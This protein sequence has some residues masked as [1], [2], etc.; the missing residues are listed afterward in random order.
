[1]PRISWTLGPIAHRGLHR[2]SRGIVENTISAV[3][4]AIER[5][6]AVEVDLQPAKG[7]AP[8]VFHDDEL[9]RLIDVK[10]LVKH[11]TPEEL[12]RLPY[13]ATRDRIFTLDELLEE[14]RGRVPLVVEVKTP[15]VEPGT[16]EAA[17]ARACKLYKGPLA[18]MSFDHRSLVALRALAPGIPLGLLSYRW[19]DDWMPS[20]GRWEKMKLR[21]LLYRRAVDAAFVAYDIDDLPAGPPLRARRRGLPLLTWTVTTEAQRQRAARYADAI[22]FEGYDP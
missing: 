7:E 14:V 11:Y 13:K 12:A 3:Q 10:G 19:D 4:A 2:Q 17:I 21:N 16:Y 8:V 1:M 6:Y 15:F 18:L 5:G 9:D 22:I 20:L